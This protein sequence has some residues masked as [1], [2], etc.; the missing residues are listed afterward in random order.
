MR[1]K[2][3][4]QGMA[5][6]LIGVLLQACGGGGSANPAAAPAATGQAIVGVRDAAGDFVSYSVDVTSL[7]L[8][9]GNGD[10]VET[11]PLTTRIDFADLADLTEF[12]TVATVP[13]GVYSQVQLNLD[14]SNAQIVVQDDDGAEVPVV[15]VDSAGKPLTRL[16]VAI[17]LPDSEP[18]RI[19]R[20]IPAMVTLDFDLAASNTIDLSAVPAQVTV[21]P[22]LSV[23]PELDA[24]RDHRVRGLLAAVDAAAASVTLKVRPFHLRTGEFGRLTFATNAETQFEINGA[25]YVGADG[26]RAVAALAM[27]TPV[28]AQG[29]VEGRTL[30]AAVVLAGTSVP[31]ANGSFVS[32]VVTARS[33]NALTVNGADID[34]ADGTHAWRSLLRVLVGADTHVNAL[35]VEP[36]T[37]G[38]GAISVGQRIVAFGAMSD[39]VTLDATEGRVRLEVTQLTGTVVQAD[40]LVVSLAELG[41]LRPAAFD[42]AGT[43]A[44]SAS[45]TDPSHYSIDTSTLTLTGIA[46]DDVVRV[47]GLVHAFGM[48]P[49]AFAAR[50]V[51]DVDTDSIGAW[52]SAS[53]RASGGTAAPFTRVGSDGIDVDL[54]DARHVLALVG[55]PRG[56]LDT[57]DRVDLLPPGTVRGTYL[58][59]VRG[60]GELHLYRDFTTLT[61]DLSGQ[62]AAGKRLV[63]I[64][65]IG[66]YNAGSL[67]LTTPRASF[68]FTAP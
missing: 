43:G 34:F 1:R 37:L 22:F 24:N 5:G 9:R 27:D 49:P 14:F 48:A 13:E 36:G 19:V 61:G 41:G 66:R 18:V 23:V 8:V 20:G 21:Q 52:L 16:T 40:P 28:V 47:R 50:T 26:L 11:V 46:P 58:V 33:G 38:I 60:S 39:A 15:A 45:D 4:L 35:G 56:A 44:S 63:Q 42:F 30:T 17:Q 6:V 57:G 55:I 25:Q 68:E 62:L 32:G 67:E 7:R 29:T 64:E 53:W 51:T 2:L 3:A 59:S 65:A 54:S 10:V 31:W 12:F